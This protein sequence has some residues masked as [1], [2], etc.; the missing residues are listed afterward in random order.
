MEKTYG[1]RLTA[2]SSGLKAG[3]GQAERAVDEF[4]K[5]LAGLRS[6]AASALSFVGISFG[7]REVLKMADEYG[8][9]M[10]R[11]K[12]VT[13]TQQEFNETQKS[14]FQIA[15]ATRAPLAETIDLYGKLAPSVQ[16][17]GG[18][19][20]EAAGIVQTVSQAIALS[21]A[22]A[23]AS[24]A[25]ILQFG[26]ALSAG[27]LRGDEFNSIIEQTPALATALANGLGVPRGKLR[28][29]AEAGELTSER[30]ITALKKVAPQVAKDFDSLPT[31]VGQSF[32]LLGNEITKLVGKA[33]QATGATRAIAAAVQG[34]A[35]NLDVVAP[36][37]GGALVG[38]LALFIPKAAA[39]AVTAARVAIAFAAMNPVAAVA[40]IAA[41][42]A[43]AFALSKS[44][45]ALEDVK[46]GDDVAEAQKIADR[47]ASIEQQFYAERSK[48]R[49]LLLGVE[50]KSEKEVREETLK[51]IKEQ[52]AG[53]QRLKTNLQEAWQA[54]ING[55]K[56]ALAEA[57]GFY[58]QAATARGN[59]KQK[60]ED[61]LAQDLP[62]DQRQK[63]FDDQATSFTK[64]AETFATFATNAAIDAQ[65]GN[66]E[67]GKKALEYATKTLELTQ[68]ASEYAEKLTNKK[69][70][71]AFLTKIGEIEEEAFK[72][73][74]KLKEQEAAE[75][76]SQAQ[77]QQ[78]QIQELDAQIS[79]LQAKASAITLEVKVQEAIANVV[80]LENE[81]A[82][83]QDKTVN[84]TVNTIRAGGGEFDGQ[85]ATGSFATGGWTGPGGKYDPAGIVHANEFVTRSEVVN[86]PGALSFLAAFNREG[87]SLLRRMRLPGFAD[88]GL[89]PSRVP[90][91]HVPAV[92]PALSAAGQALQPINLHFPNMGSFTVQASQDVAGEITRVF[93]RAALSAG[94]RR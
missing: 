94:R 38:A 39:A 51:T 76:Q 15:T 53:V 13:T 75:L 63:H 11:L 47:K 5:K 16:A 1:V 68:K 79:A 41:A 42:A 85:G 60:A 80:A 86:Q 72:A 7:G 71:A 21:G 62:E 18:T 31:T 46:T 34:L 26:Q 43:A 70:A 84:V 24:Q 40:G 52:I 91:F 20:A 3:F 9:L 54:S 83:L 33:D 58:A 57:K 12:L 73:Q 82:K 23:G 17:L 8:Q 66:A 55:A 48:L 19:S 29:L 36:A 30:I 10:A 25:S 61:L 59:A 45:K 6:I 35:K 81:L 65:S 4:G 77:A 74:G 44:M 37:I 67:R 89:V 90:V 27:A 22:S 14:L 56:E 28:E 92:H 87:I 93:Q 49:L 88:G 50:L 78:Q 2:D 69:D 32:T 64:E